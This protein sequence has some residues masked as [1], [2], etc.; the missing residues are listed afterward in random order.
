MCLFS[1][2]ADFRVD[3]FRRKDGRAFLLVWHA[4]TSDLLRRDIFF[5][6]GSVVRALGL[7]CIGVFIVVIRFGI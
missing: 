5:V 2:V 7:Q 6:H 3:V 4:R 1:K